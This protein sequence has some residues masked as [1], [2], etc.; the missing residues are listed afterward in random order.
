M[1]LYRS[2]EIQPCAVCTQ[3]TDRYGYPPYSEKKWYHESCLKEE[4]YQ[5]YLP[6]LKK[7]VGLLNKYLPN[8]R[9]IVKEARPYTGYAIVESL[10]GIEKLK[11]IIPELARASSYGR[12]S[13]RGNMRASEEN[14]MH[15]IGL[16]AYGDE[17]WDDV[18]DVWMREV[19]SPSFGD[20]M[21]SPPQAT[22]YHA[23]KGGVFCR[24]LGDRGEKVA[25]PERNGPQPQDG[26]EWEVLGES[27]NPS[28]TV[29]FLKLGKKIR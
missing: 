26:E 17:S 24:W 5:E 27:M 22:F 14:F 11:E 10:G 3:P 29:Y 16:H 6:R 21:P 8:W 18:L 15:E 12:N 1:H 23:Q 4:V 7:G 9:E 25:F 20:L 28:Q 2:E 19:N 13:Y